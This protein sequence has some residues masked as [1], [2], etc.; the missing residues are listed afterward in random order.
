MIDIHFQA[1]DINLLIYICFATWNINDIIIAAL[2]DNHFFSV[3][4]DAV[5]VVIAD[6]S[7]FFLLQIIYIE[8]CILALR[9]FLVVNFV[10]QH[11]DVP[12]IA[13]IAG[14]CD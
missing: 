2:G 11:F 12:I 8:L 1:A 4:S 9:V 10:V 13:C 7:F 6:G 3:G 14:E 5:S